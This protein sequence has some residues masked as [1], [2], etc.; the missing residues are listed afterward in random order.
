VEAVFIPVGGYFTIDSPT[1][2]KIVKE[3][4]PKAVFPM[5]YKTERVDFPITPVEVFT[6]LFAKEQV[7]DFQE[8]QIELTKGNLPKITEVWVLPYS[9]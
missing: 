3:L 7:K 1:A 4:A 2:A 6:K 9:A 5:H 8:C